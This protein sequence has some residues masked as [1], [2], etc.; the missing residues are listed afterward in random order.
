MLELGA[1]RD[2]LTRVDR[3]WLARTTGNDVH[4]FIIPAVGPGKMP[5]RGTWTD[6]VLSIPYFIT[7]KRPLP[8]LEEVNQALASGCED[9]GMSGGAVWPRIKL[10]AGTHTALCRDL[11]DL[12]AQTPNSGHL[13][14]RRSDLTA[15]QKEFLDNARDFENKKEHG[16]AYRCYR[17]FACQ[18]TLLTYS[19]IDSFFFFSDYWGARA[20]SREMLSRSTTEPIVSFMVGVCEEALARDSRALRWFRR[21]ADHHGHVLVFIARLLC[22]RVPGRYNSAPYYAWREAE[23]IELFCERLFDARPPLTLDMQQ[24]ELDRFLEELQSIHQDVGRDDFT[25]L[26]AHYLQL[27]PE[28]LKS[29]RGPARSRQ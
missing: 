19:R 7:P 29:V 15:M 8:T 27:A 2:F 23:L 9:A 1:F 6:V 14:P 10:D 26:A 24:V 4:Y 3:E 11:S 25:R 21:A 22:Q 13:R 5:Q 28:R 20:Y 12:R 18:E 16:K 17:R